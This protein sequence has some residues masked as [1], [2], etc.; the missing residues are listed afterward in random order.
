MNIENEIQEA[1][2]RYAERHPGK[3]L[4]IRAALIDMD[5]VLY[6]TMPYH[7]LAWQ[8]MMSELGVECTRDEFYLYEGM[9]G[10]ATI[11]LLMQRQFGHDASPQ[12]IK[13]LYAKKSEYFQEYGRKEPMPGADRML[14]C[15][16]DNGIDC[17]LV[18]GSGQESI[19]DSINRDYPGCFADGHRVTSRDVT[20]GKPDPEPY[21]RG[22]QIA[23]VGPEQAIVVE[24]APLGV[25]A[26]V[27]SGCFTIAV[28]TGPIPRAEFEREHPDLIFPSMEAFADALPKLLT[29]ISQ[30]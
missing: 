20:H 24:N 1:R 22:L 7:T 28:T 29:V 5:G 17:V 21:L 6:D 19:L 8:R 16:V 11:N 18:T 25:R 14:K 4:T 9:T 12:E 26:G 10:A 3:D 15:F 13:N 23:G 30:N 27:A 2:R